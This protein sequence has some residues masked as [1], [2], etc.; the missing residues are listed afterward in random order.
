MI[1][2]T[3]SWDQPGINPFRGDISSAVASYTDISKPNRVKLIQ[4]IAAHDYDEVVSI[5]KN[6]IGEDRYTDL[7]NMHFGKGVLCKHPSRNKWTNTAQERGIVYCVEDNCIIVPTVCGNVSQISR[8]YVSNIGSGIYVPIKLA[9]TPEYSLINWPTI[10]QNP[11]SP[12]FVSSVHMWYGGWYGNGWNS[13]GNNPPFTPAVP[14]PSSGI[15]AMV[16]L[17][18][19]MIINRTKPFSSR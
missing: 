14:E 5:T 15:L 19:L 9:P 17:G 16:G 6:S 8:K 11:L 10:P 7:R 13:W 3:C 1:L 2:D 4:K 18:L 12:P